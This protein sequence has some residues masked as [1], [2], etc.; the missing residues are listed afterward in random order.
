MD[1]GLIFLFKCFLE[2]AFNSFPPSHMD[3]DLTSS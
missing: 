2:S 3:S 1:V